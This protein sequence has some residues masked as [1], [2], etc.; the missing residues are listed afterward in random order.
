MCDGSVH[1]WM[2]GIALEIISALL[3]RD[4]GEIID[5]QDWQ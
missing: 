5:S 2:E 4:G 1:L 3:S